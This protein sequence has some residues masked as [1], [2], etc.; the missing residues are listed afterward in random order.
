M[1][2]DNRKTQIDAWFVRNRVEEALGEIDC[3]REKNGFHIFFSIFEN[4]FFF[5]FSLDC[6]VKPNRFYTFNNNITIYD[7]IGV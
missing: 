7:K 1:F 6:S 3:K 4:S 5:C 2:F